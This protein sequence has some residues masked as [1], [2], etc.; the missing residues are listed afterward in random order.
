MH[1]NRVS[2]DAPLFEHEDFFRDLE[3]VLPTSINFFTSCENISLQTTDAQ[4]TVSPDSITGEWS[5]EHN[6][7]RTRDSLHLHARD[8]RSVGITRSKKSMRTSIERK[9]GS[10]SVEPRP[11]IIIART[12]KSANGAL[13]AEDKLR[14]EAENR[15]TGDL[16]RSKS[17]DTDDKGEPFH[18][19]CGVCG[20]PD[21]VDIMVCCG[22]H[23]KW[24]HLG[25]I[26]LIEQP[27]EHEKWV[28]PT[29]A[30]ANPHQRKAQPSKRRIPRPSKF[31]SKPKPSKK[32]RPWQALEREYVKVL[33]QEILTEQK[34]HK[35]EKKWTE[36]S[37]HL[38][39]RFQVDRSAGAVKNYWN[40]HGRQDSGIDER[41]NKRPDRMV[42]GVQ[43]PESRR[44]ARKRK[45]KAMEEDS[46][47][48]YEED[49][50]EDDEGEESEEHDYLSS[51]KRKRRRITTS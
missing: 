11:D 34:F 9:E 51:S 10:A 47:E 50:E 6:S 39:D 5:I 27:K 49:D 13:D 4:E 38:M 1:G 25:C 44:E 3:E 35:S 23:R 12:V 42:T 20:Q 14:V 31:Q 45:R 36:I 43:D 32:D 16:A 41:K 22:N 24:F 26:G 8:I 28:C 33:M 37:K 17:D 18:E 48:T 15:T 29:C 7:E 21:G 40:R 46:E 19:I 2:S 30:S